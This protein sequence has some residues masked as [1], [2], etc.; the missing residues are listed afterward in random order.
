MAE[1]FHRYNSSNS[2]LSASHN[3][4]I[5]GH[6]WAPGYNVNVAPSFTIPLAVVE[7]TSLLRIALNTLLGF[8]RLSARI[9]LSCSGR[10]N[11]GEH[12]IYHIVQKRDGMDG[13]Y[14]FAPR[15]GRKLEQLIAAAL[16]SDTRGIK[17]RLWYSAK[18]E[19]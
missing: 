14:A 8:L 15:M 5:S 17:Q 2:M 16:L 13:L 12:L 1:L 7:E 19:L 6:H 18:L 3:S 10:M 9:A 4:C 11:L